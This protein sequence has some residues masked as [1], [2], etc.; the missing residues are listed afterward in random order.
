[1]PEKRKLQGLQ[2]RLRLVKEAIAVLDKMQRD[3]R[4]TTHRGENANGNHGGV[5]VI[6]KMRE[7]YAQQSPPSGPCKVLHF[8]ARLARVL[9]EG[10]NLSVATDSQSDAIG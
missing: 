2:R 6:A 5:D 9:K 10:E 3:E 7:E 4:K 8:P 1:M